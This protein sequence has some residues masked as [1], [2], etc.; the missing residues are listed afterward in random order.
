MESGAF[1]AASEVCGVNSIWLGFV[2]DC[3]VKETWDDWHV[4]LDEMAEITASVCQQTVYSLFEELAD[5]AG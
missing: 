1:Y 3:L 4:S 2:S 5:I